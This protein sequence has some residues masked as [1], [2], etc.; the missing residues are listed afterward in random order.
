MYNVIACS[1]GKA[2]GETVMDKK[3]RGRWGL[4]CI[5]ICFTLFLLSANAVWATKSNTPRQAAPYYKITIKPY[6]IHHLI[7]HGPALSRNASAAMQLKYLDDEISL[8]NP[9]FFSGTDDFKSGGKSDN[10]VLEAGQRLDA[11][12]SITC[13]KTPDASNSKSI[14]KHPVASM[15]TNA[16]RLHWYLRITYPSG[17]SY[18]LKEDVITPDISNKDDEFTMATPWTKQL[19]EI[20]TYLLTA[21]VMTEP[22]GKQSITAQARFVV[23][24]KGFITI[25]RFPRMSSYT[26][27]ANRSVRLQYELA[28]T[29]ASPVKVENLEIKIILFGPRTETFADEVC[30]LNAFPGLPRSY[31]LTTLPKHY[32]LD[33][34][35]ATWERQW[36]SYAPMSS[37]EHVVTR[38]VKYDAIGRISGTY[39]GLPWYRSWLIGRL[40]LK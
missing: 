4:F 3:R 17:T 38:N 12:F 37:L 25:R 21:T 5:A 26:L 1:T 29:S 24:P 22:G 7:L 23:M 13:S 30:T 2:I 9:S 32:V 20:G 40:H 10:Y 34:S 39:Q 33:L 15:T 36:V 35:D 11:K 27:D 31:I 19:T 8:Y 6:T 18:L 14:K 28:T 16:K